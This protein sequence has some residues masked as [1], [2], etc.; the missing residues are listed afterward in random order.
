MKRLEPLLEQHAERQLQKLLDKGHGDICGDF[1]GKYCAGIEK[2]WLNLSDEGAKHLEDNVYPFVQSWRTGDWEA[3]KKASDGFY[4]IARDVMADRRQTLRDPEEDPASSLL[5]EK[6][7]EGNSLDE[8]HLIGAVRQALIV[9]MIAPSLIMGAITRHLS[10]HKDLQNQFRKDPSLLP[11]AIEEFIRL[12]TP[13][14]GFARTAVCPV[15]FQGVDI[16][17]DEPLTLTYAAANRDPSQ[18]P[19]PE[20]FI[21][22][23]ENI[24]THLGFGRGK[25]RCAGM[26]LARLALKKYLEVLLRNTTD[27]DVEGE[28]EFARLPEIG[29]IGCPMRFKLADAGGKAEKAEVEDMSN[30]CHISS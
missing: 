17:A 11:S 15:T 3:V 16:P 22:D 28:C 25:H 24:A 23:R 27:F 5:L 13:Y 8:F 12:Y 21:M 29:L 18:F 14:R 7:S 10:I 20:E 30:Y 2:E 26:P 6:D 4:V 9:A 19:N 1:G